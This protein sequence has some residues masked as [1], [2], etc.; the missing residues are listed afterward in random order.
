MLP[1][2]PRRRSPPRTLAAYPERLAGAELNLLSI[3]LRKSRGRA[4]VRER[5][6]VEVMAQVNGFI[7]GTKSKMSAAA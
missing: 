3:A 7:D 2:H 5:L 4:I 1:L 6:L